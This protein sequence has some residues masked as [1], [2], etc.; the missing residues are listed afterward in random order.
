MPISL[1]DKL[2]NQ[3]HFILEKNLYL[4]PSFENTSKRII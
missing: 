1:A 3:T 4:S 2:R